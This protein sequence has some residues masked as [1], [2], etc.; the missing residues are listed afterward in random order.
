MFTEKIKPKK[1]DHP[2]RRGR[3]RPRGHTAK[4]LAARES[5]YR[6]AVSLIAERGYE[7][8][9]LRDIADQAGVSPGL[10]YKYFP[11]KRAIVLALYDEL[12]TEYVSRAER[13]KPGPWRERSLFAMKT[14]LRVLATQ[15]ETLSALVPIL[16]GDPQKG[17]FAPATDFSRRR[18][19]QVFIDAVSGAKEKLDEVQAESL[20]RILYVVHLAVILWW[21]LD[22]SPRQR[23]T[24]G[25][26][27]LLAKLGPALGLALKL[28][29]AWRTVRSLD[30]LILEG[31]LGVAPQSH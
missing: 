14:S 10:I 2:G 31:L 24:E 27:E 16:V 19:Q 15:R 25:L 21:L 1:P 30:A 26:L 4:G 29:G 7:G 13:M 22:K 11:G 23:A 20:G 18:V 17:L 6:T 28:P 5:L 8:T 3:G 9:T 12:S